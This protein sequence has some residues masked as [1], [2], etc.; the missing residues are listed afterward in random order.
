MS[1]E[2]SRG[3][4]EFQGQGFFEG[5]GDAIFGAQLD[6]QAGFGGCALGPDF[7]LDNAAYVFTLPAGSGSSGPVSGGVVTEAITSHGHVT[8][9]SFTAE[10]ADPG[11]YQ[12]T[13]ISNGNWTRTLTPTSS[14]PTFQFSAG[15]AG[16]GAPTVT[17]TI[18]K[19]NET[20]TLTYTQNSD[21]TDFSLT[22][23]NVAVAS[24]STS[25]PNGGT[26]AYT[27][28]TTAPGS[29]TET[30][31]WGSHS[32]SHTELLN[33]TA[34][35]SGVGG[36]TAT[37]TYVSGDALTTVTYVSTDGA[38]Y[39]ISDI[40]TTDF[41]S[42]G[43]TP[44]LDIDPFARADFSLS[45]TNVGSVT[46]IS[47]DGVAGTAQ[48]LPLNSHVSFAD[49]GSGAM[50]SGDFVAETFT[51]GS[52]TGYELFYSS[53]GTGGEYMEVSHGSGSVSRRA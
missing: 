6:G 3:R 2:V 30:E 36:D 20:E 42:G 1:K 10:S 28:D 16:G 48:T 45:G 9:I 31:T 25:L 7:G 21:G 22:Q 49:L 46:W 11:D 39:A 8:T 18:A 37:D 35:L 52:H 13:S 38:N 47:P 5:R 43:A 53:T 14:S 24:P 41:P 51:H 40:S 15:A 4:F 50:S 17:E 44:A 32:F 12:I 29:I 26:L 19:A 34:T 27:F 23:E 33:P